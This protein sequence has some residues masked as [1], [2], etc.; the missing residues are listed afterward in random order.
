MYILYLAHNV[1][2]SWNP[3]ET[4]WR[5]SLPTLSNNDQHLPR[6]SKALWYIF[7]WSQLLKHPDKDSATKYRI[8][9]PKRTSFICYAC[10]NLLEVSITMNARNF[11]LY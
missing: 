7:I 2:G 10:M 9:E 5:P 11:L 1:R 4:L 8:L 6:T 3:L